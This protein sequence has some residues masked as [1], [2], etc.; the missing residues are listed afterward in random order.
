MSKFEYRSFRGFN[1]EQFLSDLQGIDFSFARDAEGNANAAC[2][3]FE[4]QISQVVNK[5]APIKQAY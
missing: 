4:S 1:Q 5:H 3:L 2:E